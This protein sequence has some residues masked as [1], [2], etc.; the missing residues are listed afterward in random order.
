MPLENAIPQ[1]QIADAKIDNGVKSSG[2][3]NLIKV[4]RTICYHL[5]R[6]L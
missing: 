5:I 2:G 1:H 6:G 4:Y 3:F